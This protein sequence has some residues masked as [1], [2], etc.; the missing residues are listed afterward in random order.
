MLKLTLC[1]FALSVVAALAQFNF[2][3]LDCDYSG[4]DP[5][6]YSCHSGGA[7]CYTGGD[8]LG[9]YGY[10][11]D[12]CGPCCFIPY[13]LSREQKAKMDAK[14][15]KNAIEWLA[16]PAHLS[17]V[18][19]LWKITQQHPRLDLLPD[20]EQGPIRLPKSHPPLGKIPLAVMRNPQCP[21]VQLAQKIRLSIDPAVIKER[22]QELLRSSLKFR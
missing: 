17:S 11:E 4:G 16:N 20:I 1:F 19:E 21:T 22:H 2:C 3:G 18:G 10:C 9:G 14:I 5:S 15:M 12:K 6:C 8:P 7:A 13:G